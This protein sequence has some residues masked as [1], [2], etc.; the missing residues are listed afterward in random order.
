MARLSLQEWEVVKADYEATNLSLA[1]LSDKYGVHK[2]NISKRAKSEGWVKGKTQHLVDKKTKAIKDLY[3]VSQQSQHLNA[4]ARLAI[5]DEVTKRLELEEIFVNAAKY[6]QMR[7]NTLLKVDKA[8]SMAVLDTHSRL[9][10][11]NKETVLGK[12][13]DT[14]IQINNGAD[15]ISTLMKEIS[16][17]T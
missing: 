3:D 15:S 8:A 11:R 12:Q 1:Q 17:E 7:A 9:T 6:N 14:A 16:E 5:D 2:S 4:T 10:N 13:P